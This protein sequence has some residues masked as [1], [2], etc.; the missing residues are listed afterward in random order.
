M[1][2]FIKECYRHKKTKTILIILTLFF[3][4]VLFVNKTLIE[5]ISCLC[6]LRHIKSQK[7][8]CF[9]KQLNSNGS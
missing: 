9:K 7:K 2:E 6:N 8:F 1:N 3:R 5:L 4:I